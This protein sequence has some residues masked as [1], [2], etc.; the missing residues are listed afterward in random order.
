MNN[1]KRASDND[2]Y[3]GDAQPN[4]RKL[5]KAIDDSSLDNQIVEVLQTKNHDLSLQSTSTT[6]AE[7]QTNESSESVDRPNEETSSSHKEFGIAP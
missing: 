4:I 6:P 7:K 3:V 1:S 5:A 2:L